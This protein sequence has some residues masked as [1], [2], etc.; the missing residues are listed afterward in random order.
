MRFSF[1]LA[2]VLALATPA[3]AQAADDPHHP[4]GQSAAP[5]GQQGATGMMQGSMKCPIAGHTDGTLAFL[6]TELAITPAQTQVWEAFATAYRSLSAP[7]GSMGAEMMHDGM[8]GGSAKAMTKPLPDRIA[9][10]V[11]MMDRHLEAAKKLQAAIKPLYAALNANQKKTA[12][13]VMPMI[14]MIAVM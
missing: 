7:R 2:L 12:D 14:A 10:H 3:M 5:A 6:K 1:P 9:V 4:P 11:Q 13:D 8:M